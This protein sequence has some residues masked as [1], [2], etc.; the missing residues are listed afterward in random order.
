MEGLLA[1][2]LF[3]RLNAVAR[4]HAEEAPYVLEYQVERGDEKERYDRREEYAK[5]QAY[6]HGYE[7]L[8]LNAGLQ[9]YRQKPQS[10]RKRG[11]KYRA[12]PAPSGLKHRLVRLPPLLPPCVY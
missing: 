7:E 3:K 4:F 11:E 2:L 10:G 5:T 6:R 1:F 9:Y 8:G 12:K